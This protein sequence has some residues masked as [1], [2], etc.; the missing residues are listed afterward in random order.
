MTPMCDSSRSFFRA[1]AVIVVR[2]GR[3]PIGAARA[4]ALVNLRRNRTRD[5][6]GTWRTNIIFHNPRIA[7]IASDL[8]DGDYAG[9]MAYF[10]GMADVRAEQ[11]ARPTW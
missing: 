10:T 5:G 8:L 3:G 7:E 6:A 9:R 1:C 2:P 4:C 11:A